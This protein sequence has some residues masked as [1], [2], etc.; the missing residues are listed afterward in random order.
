[1]CSSL[2]FLSID[3]CVFHLD[4]Y[5]LLTTMQR[6]RGRPKHEPAYYHYLANRGHLSNP[7]LHSSTSHQRFAK[8]NLSAI[9]RNMEV[10]EPPGIEGNFQVSSEQQ[11]HHALTPTSGERME[12]DP[13]EGHWGLPFIEE[14]PLSNPTSV[15]AISQASPSSSLSS[16]GDSSLRHLTKEQLRPLFEFCEA[17]SDQ[18]FC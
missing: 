12:W 11:Q 6:Q 17:V 13:P 3:H 14:I 16:M 8:L 4:I 15:Q 9:H 5:V 18:Q 2:A 7:S 1:V 10:H